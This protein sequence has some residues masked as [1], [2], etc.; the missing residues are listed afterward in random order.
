MIRN[1]QLY[2]VTSLC[3]RRWLIQKE[4]FDD[5]PEVMKKASGETMPH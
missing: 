2:Y 4:Q 3:G 1:E 5:A